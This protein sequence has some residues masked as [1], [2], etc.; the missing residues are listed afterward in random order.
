V[1]NGFACAMTTLG[2]QCWGWNDFGT[3]GDGTFD[4]RATPAGISASNITKVFAG[5]GAAC[6]IS[7]AG[8]L[9]CWGNTSADAAKKAIS[10]PVPTEEVGI[11]NVK[12][13]AV[14]LDSFFAL[15]PNDLKAW[16]FNFTGTF[17]N[18]STAQSW[19][20]EPGV[21]ANVGLLTHISS[22][23]EHACGLEITGTA[24]CWGRNES[25]QTGK[26]SSG[27][28]VLSP[29]VVQGLDALVS[30]GAGAA[31]SCSLDTSGTVQCWG[32]NAKSTLGYD[33]GGAAS[34]TPGAVGMPAA[35]S[36]SVG[37]LHNCALAKAGSVYC[38]G[39]NYW[40]QLGT[41]DVTDQLTPVPVKW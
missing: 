36:L 25:G 33:T 28:N 29:S 1:G 41:G 10:Q 6:G 24:S 21:S 17:G 31:H 13:A 18:G 23:G 26:D 3:L 9:L 4:S 12:D 27:A 11:A 20:G 2:P 40:G 19:L 16:G 22:F 5:Y 8:K 35:A 15:G 30:V 38:W 14:G 34:A 37:P 7:K 39:F 32:S